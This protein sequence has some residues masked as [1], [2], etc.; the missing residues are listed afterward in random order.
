M[1][2]ALD[3][4]GGDYAPKAVVEGAAIALARHPEIHYV[5]FGDESKIA[6]LLKRH[7]KLADR[8]E[9]VH[10][11]DVVTNEEKPSAALRSGRNSSMQLAIN[12][13]KEKRTEACVS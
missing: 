9:I 5:L 10:T 8:S 13:V 7:H 3:A 6:P 12:S 4:M 11:P 2:I 1:K